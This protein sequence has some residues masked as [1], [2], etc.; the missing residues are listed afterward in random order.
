MVAGLGIP[1]LQRFVLGEAASTLVAPSLGLL[2]TDSHAHFWDPTLLDYPW[3]RNLPI[4]GSKLP[5]DYWEAA[6][7]FKMEKLVFVQAG[8][9]QDQARSEVAWVEKLARGEP[10]IS[11][12]VAFAPMDDEKALALALEDFARR[13]LV[14]GIRHLLQSE[15]EL[16][17]CLRPQFV[18]GVRRLGKAKLAFEVGARAEQLPAVAKLVERCPEVSFV[19]DHLGNPR[20]GESAFKPWDESIRRLAALPNI[21]CKVS[22]AATKADWKSWKPEQLRPYIDH[23]LQTFGFHRVMFGS[24]WPVCTLACSL[25][26]WLEVLSEMTSGC[27]RA[28]RERL[29]A[30]NANKFFGTL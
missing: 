14:K 8:C 13:P 20:I 2:I 28:E 4:G 6:A 15:P 27:T 21:A 11:A 22:G 30:G 18:A 5:A 24:D 10:R 19:L 25:R 23:V 29:F 9:R 16:E 12:I 3:L 26:R 7:G 17:F 1:L